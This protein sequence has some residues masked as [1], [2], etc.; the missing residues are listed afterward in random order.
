MIIEPH[1]YG[2]VEERHFTARDLDSRLVGE[3]QRFARQK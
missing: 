2:L 3:T 1:W